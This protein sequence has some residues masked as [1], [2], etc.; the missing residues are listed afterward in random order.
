MN[1]H[2]G[3]S[4][5]RLWLLIRRSVRLDLKLWATGFA[6]VT[7]VYFLIS[8]MGMYI[9]AQT[10][11][12]LPPEFFGHSS[13]VNTGLFLYALGGYLMTSRIFQE[14]HDPTR[15]YVLLT[16]PASV[17]EKFLSAWLVTA[18]LYTMVVMAVLFLMELVCSVIDIRLF[19]AGF[20][21]FNPFDSDV[22]MKIIAYFGL[23]SIFLLGGVFFRKNNF[24]KTILTL[25]VVQIVLT[26]V[27]G[28]ILY[29]LWTIVPGFPENAFD[30]EAI[31]ELAP[32]VN[33]IKAAGWIMVM[34][35][36]LPVGYYRFKHRQL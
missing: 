3:F 16:L 18:P 31:I 1:D 19:G 13:A 36:L 17:K 35:I 21:W 25:V 9:Q 14:L 29:L 30:R 32:Q 20:G 26:M 27:F 11:A 28:L 8:L 7:G 6:A 12:D 10:A 24:I 22:L 5:E 33:V 4:V 23:H 34:L 15:G 2:P